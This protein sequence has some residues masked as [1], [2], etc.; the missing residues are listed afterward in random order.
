MELLISILTGILF[1]AGIYLIL[2]RRLLPVIL[3]TNLLTYSALLF[4]ITSGKLK[5]GNPPILTEG[6]TNYNYVDPLPQ[7]LILTAIVIN[8]A[9]T[10]YCLVLAYRTYQ[11]T[12]TDDL[13]NLRGVNEPD[14]LDVHHHGEEDS[15]FNSDSSMPNGGGN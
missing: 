9:V 14:E 11:D 12:G 8:F 13:E 15:P 6:I 4:L 3:G 1:A 2:S 5:R 7:A 10:A